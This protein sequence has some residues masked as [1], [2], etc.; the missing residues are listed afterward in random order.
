M[1]EPYP[2]LKNHFDGQQSLK[3]Y[4]EQVTELYHNAPCG[5]HSLDA[6]GL[7]VQINDTELNWLGYTRS[8]LVGKK[9]FVDLLTPNSIEVFQQHFSQSSPCQPQGCMHH[10]ELEMLR[11]DGSVIP[12]LINSTAVKDAEDNYLLSRFTVFNITDRKETEAALRQAYEDLEV[13]VAER[14]SELKQTVI[15]LEQEILERQRSE[16]ER[17]RT[18]KALRQS[19]SQLREKAQRERLLNRL[20]NQIRSSLDLNQ[21]LNTAVQAIYHH[22][23]IDRCTFLW[24]RLDGDEPYWEVVQEAKRP[25]LPSRAGLKIP[26]ADILP[27]TEQCFKRRI[28][29]IDDVQIMTERSSQQFFLDQGY[30]AVLGLPIHTQS[31][32]VGIVSC[33]HSVGT[34]TWDADEVELLQSVADNLSIAIDQA[35]LYKQSRVTAEIAQMQAQQLENALQE[36]QRTQAQM[37]QSEKMSSLGQLVAG[38]A[39]EINNPVNFIYGNLNHANEYTQDVLNLLKLYQKHYPDPDAEILAE[40]ETIDLEFIMEDLP[41]L[42]SSMKVGADRIQ[43]IVW[44]L[45]TFSR[46]DEAAFKAVNLHEGIDSTLMILQ[47]RLKARPERPAIEIIKEYGQL[48]LV[49]C[50]AGQLNQVFMNILSNAID[51]MEE[52]IGEQGAA[53]LNHSAVLPPQICIR[54]EVQNDRAVIHIT[55]TGPGMPEAVRQRIFDPF[56]TTKPVGKGTGMGMSISYQIVTEKHGGTLQCISAPGKGTKFVIEIPIR[57]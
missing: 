39:H 6:D 14:T 53:L 31:E 43:K 50:Y 25:E 13:R 18:E 20:T 42:L 3:R 8:E 37:I 7:F 47:N 38:V 22:L 48:P 44:S 34:H 19:E 29:C 10:V 33:T 45:R 41:K 55:D 46:M 1:S 35:E 51:A 27:L 15:Q 17:E 21:I 49:E 54:T 28:I 5:Y 2:E 56:F 24:Y 57:Q 16:A 26:A 23:E 40:A 4:A 11:S 32:E 30:T 36:L 9:Q 12:V 52:A